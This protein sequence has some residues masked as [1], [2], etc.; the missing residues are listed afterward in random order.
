MLVAPVIVNVGKGPSM[1]PPS[2]TSGVEV[3]M[4]WMM[5]CPDDE[6]IDGRDV[7]G[8]QTSSN[9]PG[10]RRVDQLAPSAQLLVP[11]PPVQVTLG[12]LQA[13][14]PCMSLSSVI[15]PV[16]LPVARFAPAGWLSSSVNCSLP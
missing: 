2:R 10:G 12:F 3:S 4:L 16:A 13:P 5:T 8:M 9:G 15:M 11:A 1:L 7:A 14:F 6:E